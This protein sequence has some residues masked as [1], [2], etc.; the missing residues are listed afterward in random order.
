MKIF[1]PVEKLKIFTVDSH[2]PTLWS[3]Q[4]IFHLLALLRGLSFS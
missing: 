3:L 4:F 1:K 2:V